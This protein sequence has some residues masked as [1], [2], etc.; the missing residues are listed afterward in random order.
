MGASNVVNLA[1]YRA[2]RA[3]ARGGFAGAVQSLPKA[4]GLEQDI[5]LSAPSESSG[6]VVYLTMDMGGLVGQ[7]VIN[8]GNTDDVIDEITVAIA[9]NLEVVFKNITA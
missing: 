1:E 5:P 4:S 7:V 3:Y 9:E 6:T 8:D 2:Y